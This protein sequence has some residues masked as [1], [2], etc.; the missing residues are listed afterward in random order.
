MSVLIDLCQFLCNSCKLQKKRPR[1]HK[2]VDKL[3]CQISKKYQ[4]IFV[5]HPQYFL[6]NSDLNT[7][8]YLPY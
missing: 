2:E 6:I 3:Y 4:V 7:P 1:S 8:E 5:I